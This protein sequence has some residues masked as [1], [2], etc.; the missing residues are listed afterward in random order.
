MDW[1]CPTIQAVSS[2]FARAV[3][4]ALPAVGG[5]RND[6]KPL[7]QETPQCPTLRCRRPPLWTWWRD[8][9]SVYP[10][11]SDNYGLCSWK[12]PTEGSLKC[13]VLKLRLSSFSSTPSE[14]YTQ[15]T[16]RL[17]LCP[18]RSHLPVQI[19]CLR[20]R[21]GWKAQYEISAEQLA[22]QQSM[23]PPLDHSGGMRPPKNRPVSSRWLRV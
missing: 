20:R 14:I 22:A 2:P 11:P 13:K 3:L 17:R 9:R 8:Y 6:E 4:P 5:G 1:G 12:E 18:E 19:Q 10:L 16:F 23:L 7:R 15:F 21:L